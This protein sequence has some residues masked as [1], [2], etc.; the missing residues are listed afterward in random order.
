MASTE[1]EHRDV[2]GDVIGWDTVEEAPQL[3]AIVGD[4]QLFDRAARCRLKSRA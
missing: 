4:H 1:S 2:L 3:L